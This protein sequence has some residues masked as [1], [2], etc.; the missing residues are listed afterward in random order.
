V[1]HSLSEAQ[2]KGAAFAKS[3]GAPTLAEL[4]ALPLDK[5]LAVQR[6]DNAPSAYAVLDNYFLTEPPAE[7]F[8]KGHA[9]HVPLL[10]GTNS[11]EAPATAVLGEGAKA[12]LA[13]YRA[14]LKR[15]L[16]DKADAIFSLYPARTDADVMPMATAV[17]SDDFLALSTWKWFDLQRKTGAPVYLYYFTHIRPRA[18]TDPPG[19]QL[20]WGALHSSEIE[21]ALGTLDANPRYAWT[22]EDRAVSATMNGY[23]AAFIKTGN[24]NEGTLP[25]WPRAS[26]D[27]SAIRRQIID[28]R[29]YS[30]PFVEQHRYVAA[31]PLLYMH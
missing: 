11:Q 26:S 8:A 20:P 30:A 7:T 15:T 6:N 22:D 1:P 5:L 21:Y 3:I 27:A 2:E 13:T 19:A 12:D 31:D 16:G 18:I 29:T 14:G 4:R 28:V 23:V 17:A 10:V 25:D 9:A 24:P